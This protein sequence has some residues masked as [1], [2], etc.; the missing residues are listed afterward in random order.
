MVPYLVIIV[1][2][3]PTGLV[4][5]NLISVTSAILTKFGPQTSWDWHLNTSKHG[6]ANAR[7][8]KMWKNILFYP[9]ITIKRFCGTT[10]KNKGFWV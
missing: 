3:T 7:R 9:L 4:F 6:K 2:V 5:R 1:Y 8:K 10:T